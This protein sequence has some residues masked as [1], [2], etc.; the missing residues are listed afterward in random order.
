ML[1]AVALLAAVMAAGAPD[2]VAQAQATFM[3]TNL[4][5]A[6]P[7]SLRQ[8]ILDANLAIGADTV[9]FRPGLSGT[10][11]GD[12]RLAAACAQADAPSRGA[13]TWKWSASSAT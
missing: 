3:V 4:D 1:F 10:S 13:R 5:D 12:L 7:G 9:G 6:G 8:V 2:R 11:P